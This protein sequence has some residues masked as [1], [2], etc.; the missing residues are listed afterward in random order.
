MTGVRFYIRRFRKT[1]WG[2]A[3]LLWLGWCAFSPPQSRA[4]GQVTISAS[5]DKSVIHIGDLITYTVKVTRDPDVKVKLPA[6]GENLGGF[7][8]R[9]YQVHKPRKEGGKVVDQFDYIISTFDVGEFEIPPIGIRYTV[10]PDTT[11][12][13]LRTE[14]IKITVESLKPSEEG[15]IRDIK[16]PVEIPFDWRPWLRWGLAALVVLLLAAALF[17]YLRKRRRGEPL[18]PK[19]VEV[20]RPPHEVAYE[21]L[22]KLLAQDLLSQG[23]LKRF[24]SEISEIIRRYV[25][26]RFQIAALESTTTDLL[27]EL[28]RLELPEEQMELFRRFLSLCD[29]VKF[30]KYVPGG[31][32]N[33]EV[34]ALARRIVDETKWVE[35]EPEAGAAAEEPVPAGEVPA[36][37]GKEA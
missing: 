37:E 26:G 4:Q 15:D 32:E 13:L 30:A 1:V 17:F 24:Y 23:A 29:L 18:L 22:E 27:A 16:S 9:D 10:P 28:N 19:K 2:P 25:E 20:P 11:E 34:V 14:A 12:H 7:E 33:E 36:T 6:V 35:P 3:V 8:I 31:E 21:E 5:V